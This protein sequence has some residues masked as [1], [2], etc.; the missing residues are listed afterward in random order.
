VILSFL[1][2]T[3]VTVVTITVAYF[4]RSLPHELY[5]KLDNS[6]IDNVTDTRFGSIFDK[7]AFFARRSLEFITN[8][9]GRRKP[10]SSP[11]EL[12]GS[13][14]NS[15]L[16]KE[17][18]EHKRSAMESFMLSLSDQQLFTGIAVV[19]SAFSRRCQISYIS[20]GIATQLA[21]CSCI[22][23]LVTLASL[24]TYLDENGRTKRLRISLVTIMF[25]LRL[26]M[27]VYISSAFPAMPG[28]QTLLQCATHDLRFSVLSNVLSVAISNAS[29]LR[30]LIPRWRVSVF[31]E[32]GIS[33]DAPERIREF[34]RQSPYHNTLSRQVFRKTS[35]VVIIDQYSGSMWSR[36]MA[37]LL[38]S[39]YQAFAII[40]GG[41]L[42][43]KN[44]WGF[45]QIMP[46]I[47][48]ALPVVSAI[49][50]YWGK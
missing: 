18:E 41:L 37:I 27:V 19:I 39:G 44:E 31:D 4:T 25:V 12:N 23:H 13:S 2:A 17:Y 50:G 30:E 36:L 1:L 9:F 15:D 11:R 29:G 47:L 40:W 10:S 24:R 22:T 46:V 49:E 7:I 14:I 45:G 38:T 43:H 6:I 16:N 3:S 34:W 48:I 26:A 32:S 8:L 5:N 33:I 35:F 42:H 21:W 28:D 20:F